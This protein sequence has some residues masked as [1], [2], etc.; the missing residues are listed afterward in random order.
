[1]PRRHHVHSLA[2][3]NRRCQWDW[4]GLPTSHEPVV[5]ACFRLDS[6]FVFIRFINRIVGV[7]TWFA[8]SA[9]LVSWRS[10][11]GSAWTVNVE[12]G[13]F[14]AIY[15]AFVRWVSHLDT[16]DLYIIPLYVAIIQPHSVIAASVNY[17]GAL[18]QLR[19]LDR[20]ASQAHRLCVSYMR[21]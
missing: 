4:I 16:P 12:H 8:C 18:A 14:V 13:L 17:D 15:R 9:F 20:G 21:S 11:R 2:V 7:R 5:H 6:S 19:Q 1:M 3:Q 10:V